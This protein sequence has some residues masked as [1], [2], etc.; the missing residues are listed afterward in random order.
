MVK[1]TPMGWLAAMPAGFRNEVLCRAEMRRAEAGQPLYLLGED[2]R[3]LYGLTEGIVEVS[4]ADAPG[5]SG[6]IYLARRGWWFGALEIFTTRPRRF[7]I[8]ARTDCDLLYV[9]A[10]QVRKICSMAPDYWEYFARLMCGNYEAMADAVAMM[11]DPSPDRRVATALFIL[12]LRQTEPSPRI[13]ATQPD[14]A[15]IANVSLRSA[16]SALARME[17]DRLVKRGYG[18]VDI[19]DPDRLSQS[20]GSDIQ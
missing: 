11:R 4:I 13:E 3:G 7:H 19:L 20:I 17:K 10:A 5:V 8:Q 15:S 2:A 6:L 9:P 18:T 1:T 14:I 12:Y 16:A